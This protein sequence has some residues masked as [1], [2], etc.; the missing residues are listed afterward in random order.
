MN[1]H[2]L[3]Q[4]LWDR[5]LGTAQL[6]FLLHGLLQAAVKVLAVIQSFNLEKISFKVHVVVGRIHFLTGCWTEGLSS[7]LAIGQTPSLE[8]C[9][10]NLSNMAP[11]FIKAHKLRRLNRVCQQDGSHSLLLPNHRS[12]IPSMLSYSISQMQVTQGEVM[13]IRRLD[14][15]T[16][17]HN[18]QAEC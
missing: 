18:T 8:L 15:C 2:L 17:Y 16:S 7:L 13:T 11:C 12:A 6:G 14:H 9:H 1:T 3:S 5:V 10:K 4:L